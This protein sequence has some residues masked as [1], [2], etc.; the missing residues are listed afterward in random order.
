MDM[1]LFEGYL[2]YREFSPPIGALFSAFMKAFGDGA[3]KQP[4]INYGRGAD[5]PQSEEEQLAELVSI[6]GEI[7]GT[8]KRGGENNGT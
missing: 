3:D 8:V 7:G 5:K 4:N 6:F 2:R 1:E